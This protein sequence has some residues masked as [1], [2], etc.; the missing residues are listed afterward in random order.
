M[1]AHEPEQLNRGS[2]MDQL[3]T[4]DELALGQILPNRHT[5]AQRVSPNQ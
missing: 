2:L 3:L 4:G 5:A 1:S